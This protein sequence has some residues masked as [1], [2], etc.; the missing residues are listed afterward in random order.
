MLPDTFRQNVS[1]GAMRYGDLDQI[2][3]KLRFEA[4]LDPA[5][6]AEMKFKAKLME[7]N[8]SSLQME[9]L[10]GRFYDKKTWS[11]LAISLRLPSPQAV[12]RE[13]QYVL[14]LLRERGFKL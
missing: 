10:L 1:V 7:Y 4:V 8:L 3:K 12:I 5:F 14:K 13:C 11:E 6:E 2:M 9:I